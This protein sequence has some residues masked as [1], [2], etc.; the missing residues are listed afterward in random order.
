MSDIVS[1]SKAAYHYLIRRDAEDR[2]KPPERQTPD[3]G[4]PPIRLTWKW[5]KQQPSTKPT[6]STKLHEE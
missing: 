4:S 6:R 1:L 5:L 3:Q 2:G